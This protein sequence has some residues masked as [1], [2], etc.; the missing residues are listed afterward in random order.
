MRMLTTMEQKGGWMEGYADAGPAS[1]EACP[2]L[3]LALVL[4]AV[5]LILCSDEIKHL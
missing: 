4:F 3:A 2:W 1:C 5:G